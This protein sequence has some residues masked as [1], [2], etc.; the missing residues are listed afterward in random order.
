MDIFDRLWDIEYKVRKLKE[1]REETFEEAMPSAVAYKP[2]KV[3]SSSTGYRIEDAVIKMTELEAQIES[4][5]KEKLKWQRMIVKELHYLPPKEKTVIQLRY[6]NMERWKQ[7]CCIMD[8]SKQRAH[9][10]CRQGRE[11]IKR[12]NDSLAN[13]YPML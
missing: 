6:L 2:D 1:K 11:R 12:K 8:I 13:V 7:V 5:E 3:Q 4:L 10:L 9:K